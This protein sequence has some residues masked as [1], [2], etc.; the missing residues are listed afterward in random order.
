MVEERQRR[1][2]PDKEGAGRTLR[3]RSEQGGRARPTGG[4]R[5]AQPCCRLRVCCVRVMPACVRVC[6]Q[7]YA[8][9]FTS[10]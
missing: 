4:D 10:G 5:V 7:P 8:L 6:A 3:E 1:H 2:R 9:T